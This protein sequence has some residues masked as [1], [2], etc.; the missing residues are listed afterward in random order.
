ML[1]DY[2]DYDDNDHSF[3]HGVI[4]VLPPGEADFHET[5]EMEPKYYRAVVED[6]TKVKTLKNK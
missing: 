4:P 6:E 2:N 3:T 1:E 5:G